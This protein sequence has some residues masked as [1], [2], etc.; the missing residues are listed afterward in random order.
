MKLLALKRGPINGLEAT[1]TLI[2]GVNKLHVN[3]SQAEFLTPSSRFSRALLREDELRPS[4]YVKLAL[5]ILLAK[6]IP[7]PTP[8]TPKKA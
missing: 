8:N 6:Y 1:V 5:N 7:N 3:G 4:Y 2:S